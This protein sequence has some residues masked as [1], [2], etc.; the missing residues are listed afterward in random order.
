[1][2]ATT[3]QVMEDFAPRTDLKLSRKVLVTG[4]A[5]YIG[6][7]MTRV[8]Q[9]A[10]HEVVGC[11]TG[12]FED[13]DL[14]SLPNDFIAIRKD[15]REISEADLSGFDAVIHLAA[16]SNDPLGELNPDLTFEINYQASVR[17]AKFAKAAG[18]KRYLYSSSCSM[19]GSA[20]EDAVSEEAP[21][22]PLT[23]YAESKVRVEEEVS[24]LAGDGFTPIFLRNATAYG[25]SPRFRADLVL[26]NLS[27]WAFTTKSIRIMSD[28]TPW[29]P[30][31][32]IEDI[33]R[34]FAAALTAPVELVHNQAF[35]VGRN[36]ENYRVRDIANIVQEVIP[37]CS[38]AYAGAGEPDPRSYRVDFSK[39][40]RTLPSYQPQWDARRGVRELYGRFLSHGM[41]VEDFQ[42]G[43][44][45]RLVQLKRLLDSARLDSSLRW[46]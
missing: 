16:L 2:T 12:Y 41:T 34:A 30:I 46:S 11:D 4:H 25:A 17:L 6:T 7:V 38:V 44:F 9:A 26:N 3:P 21:L 18:V 31:V 45:T 39:I 10:G 33:S 36:S 8:L 43:R 19:Y 20:G 35:N 22:R 24:K 13:C 1:M 23:A 14:D 28:G 42:S 37:G 27:C 32:H 40:A 15:I 29:R 5:G